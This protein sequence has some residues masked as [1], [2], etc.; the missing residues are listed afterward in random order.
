MPLN[1]VGGSLSQ[2]GR[3]LLALLVLGG[4]LLRLIFHRKL[5]LNLGL[6][7]LPSYLKQ[8]G[9]EMCETFPQICFFAESLLIALTT[10][11]HGL[12]AAADVKGW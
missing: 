10:F 11:M 12:Y 9:I 7:G 3:S 1:V 5:T 6:R 8:C 4:S 2:G